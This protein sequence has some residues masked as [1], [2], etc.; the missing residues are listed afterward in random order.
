M[1]ELDRLYNELSEASHQL[2]NLRQNAGGSIVE[3]EALSIRIENLN[4]QIR[5]ILKEVGKE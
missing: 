1:T 2:Y 4:N 3:L 5:A